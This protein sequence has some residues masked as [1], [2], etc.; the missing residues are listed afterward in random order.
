MQAKATA[1]QT[2]QTNKQSKQLLL[3]FEITLR[4]MKEGI[5]SRSFFPLIILHHSS[6]SFRRPPLLLLSS[7]GLYKAKKKK[8]KLIK[9]KKIFIELRNNI[10][11][12]VSI[13]LFNLREK[14][15][16]TKSTGRRWEGERNVRKREAA[17]IVDIL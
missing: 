1:R 11:F 13:F 12:N 6:S 2:R 5:I 15:E 17:L 9:N 4:R 3:L 7:V 8:K 10:H 14:K 16:S